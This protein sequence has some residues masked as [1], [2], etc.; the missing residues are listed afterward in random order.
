MDV[1]EKYPGGFPNDDSVSPHNFVTMYWRI[2]LSLPAYT[3]SI[4][5][6]ESSMDTK[7]TDG[8]KVSTYA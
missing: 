4:C 8:S 6:E 5:N 1:R 2:G 7:D 3:N